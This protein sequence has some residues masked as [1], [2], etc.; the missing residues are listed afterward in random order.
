MLEVAQR[1]DNGH[2]RIL[3]QLHHSVVRVDSRNNPVKISAQNPCCILHRLSSAKLKLVGGQ[4]DR[5][6][7]KSAS[8]N[9]ETRPRPV[10][11]FSKSSPAIFPLSVARDRPR[12]MRVLIALALARTLSISSLEASVT[13]RKLFNLRLPKSSETE[14]GPSM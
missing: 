9:L 2:S 10:D 1:V 11:G 6:P 13:E 4:V 7:T 5:V 14:D 12:L 3:R 8:S